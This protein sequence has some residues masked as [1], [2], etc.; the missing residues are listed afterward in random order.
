MEGRPALTSTPDLLAAFDAERFRFLHLVGG[1]GKTTLMYAL[2][3]AHAEAGRTAISTT[4]TRILPPRPEES[5]RLLLGEASA[6]E[7]RAALERDRHVSFAARL[8]PAA[9][10]LVGHAPAYLSALA[11]ARVAD[12]MIVEADGA[13]GRPLKAHTDGEPVVAADADG[14]VLVV[15][16]SCLGAP[17]SSATVHRFEVLRARYGAAEGAPL[18]ADLVARVLV[19]DHLA[20]IPRGAAAIVFVAGAP[21]AARAADVDALASRL[22][23]EARIERVVLGDVLAGT[24]RRLGRR[25][26]D[27]LPPLDRIRR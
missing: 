17:A 11:A 23:A 24:L 1:G 15:G 18:S 4:S 16:A 22:L 25:S 7:V 3:R 6:D 5:P 19:E 9:G 26:G 2:A 20:C 10:K 14:V 12:H 27:A 8:D 21:A 13:A